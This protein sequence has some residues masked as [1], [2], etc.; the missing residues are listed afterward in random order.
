ME[1]IGDALM[2]VSGVADDNDCHADAIAS[3]ALTMMAAAKAVT[4]P[5]ENSHITVSLGGRTTMKCIVDIIYL[6]EE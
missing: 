6:S 4:S 5:Q 1:T 2:V 3:T